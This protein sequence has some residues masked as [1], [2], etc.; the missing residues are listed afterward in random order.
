MLV[1][2]KEL[3]E[4]ITKL[5]RSLKEIIYNPFFILGLF[6]IFLFIRVFYLDADPCFLKRPG[7]VGDEGYWAHNARNAILFGRWMIDDYQ[8]LAT[9]PLFSVMAY[10]SFKLFGVGLF[11]ARLVS[12]IA[13]WLTLV[14]LYFFIKDAWNKKAAVI[15]VL[16]LGFNNAFLMY[17]RLG[18]VESSMIF[19]L[20]ATLYLWYKGNNNWNGFY[21]LSGVTFA[22]AI[23]TKLTAFYFVP[24]I[25]ILWIFE[26]IQK[27]LKKENAVYFMIGAV[28]PLL[29]H[30]LF[31]VIPYWDKLY[32]F[33]SASSEGKTILTLPLDI[34]RV[35]FNYFLGLPSVFLL[36]IPV[37]LYLINI[38]IKIDYG[39]KSTY[40]NLKESIQAM[41]FIDMVTLSWIIGGVLGIILGDQSDRRFVMFIIPITILFTK[42]LLN[43]SVFDLGEVIR[44]TTKIFGNGEA[45]IK[46]VTCL[47]VFLPIYSFS[48]S[49]FYSI[50]SRLGYNASSILII[51]VP[52]TFTSFKIGRDATVVLLLIFGSL[53]LLFLLL[54]TITILYFK[55][56]QYLY[57]LII[58]VSIGCL[59]AAPLH[60]LVIILNQ[61]FSAISGMESSYLALSHLLIIGIISMIPFFY[62][63]FAFIW[64]KNLLKITPKFIHS[65]LIIYLVLNFTVIGIG[66]ISPT[67]T[68]AENSRSLQ[69]YI[70][71][72]DVI[73]GPLGHELSFENEAFPLW[74]I[75]HSKSLGKLNRNVSEYNPKF[76]LVGMG[77]N[78]KPTNE[79]EWP[80]LNEFSNITFVK[81]IELCPYPFTEHY[82]SILNLYKI[83]EAN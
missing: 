40:S 55:R 63:L 75:P 83:E 5:S 1:R 52:S 42:I 46:I 9:G 57:V 74:Y 28:V 73:I 69:N 26:H 15:T 66:L 30:V 37:I 11:Q 80:R 33:L 10:T 47:L 77:S 60:T 31:F 59:I 6:L 38:A 14:L 44:H 65:L 76:L 36:L 13:G 54:F 56:F 24:A 53:L 16:I 7:D 51:F 67:F 64:R 34:A 18:L 58:L 49:T 82:K 71:K 3:V 72:G 20:V 41:N 81:K 32:P 50:F 35:P 78:G 62:L 22:L 25:I 12:A 39:T 8:A 23:L 70:E 19:F 43:E 27:T 48:V 4:S 2:L 61:H 45:K 21:V 79:S 68:I 17:N 29:A